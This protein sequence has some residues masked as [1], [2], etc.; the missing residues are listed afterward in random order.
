VIFKES[1]D[2]PPLCRTLHLKNDFKYIFIII[3]EMQMADEYQKDLK[4]T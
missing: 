1:I 2:K 3:R 4:A